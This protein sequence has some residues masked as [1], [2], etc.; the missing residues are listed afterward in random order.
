MF[1]T[2]EHVA[3][4]LLRVVEMKRHLYRQEWAPDA[5]FVNRVLTRFAPWRLKVAMNR[6]TFRLT[7][8]ATDNAPR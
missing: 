5:C 8:A 6:Q 3:A 2:P 7:R 1:R 4:R